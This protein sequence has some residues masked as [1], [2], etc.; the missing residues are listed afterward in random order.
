MADPWENTGP[1]PTALQQGVPLVNKKTGKTEFVPTNSVQERIDSGE[2]E[3]TGGVAA[4]APGGDIEVNPRELTSLR[5]AGTE[6]APDVDSL[7]RANQFA[8]E[9]EQSR[10]DQINNPVGRAFTFAEGVL[11]AFSMGVIDDKTFG[12]GFKLGNKMFFKMLNSATGEEYYIPQEEYDKLGLANTE[13]RRDLLT[14]ARQDE[15]AGT[16][17][18][19]EVAGTIGAL[20]IPGGPA[21]GAV[22]VGKGMGR[23][24]AQTVLG[25]ARAARLPF[26]TRA[27]EEAGAG[28]ILGGVHSFNQQVSDAI[29]EDKPFVA[30]AVLHEA[31]QGA[32]FGLGLGALS[33][34]ATKLR[35]AARSAVADGNSLLNLKSPLSQSVHSDIREAI[36]GFDGALDTHA[37]QMEILDVLADEGHVPKSGIKAYRSAIEEATTTQTHLNELDMDSALSGKDD[38]LAVNWRRAMEDYQAK[39]VKVDDVAERARSISEANQFGQARQNMGG[40]IDELESAGRNTQMEV[41]S[42][43]GSGQPGKLAMQVHAEMMANPQLARAYEEIYGRPWTPPPELGGEQPVTSMMA[44]GEIDTGTQLGVGRPG[45]ANGV[46]NPIVTNEPAV[47]EGR[48]SPL[49]SRGTKVGPAEG[50]RP[51]DNV[52]Q[53]SDV[54]PVV[55]RAANAK[56]FGDFQ[57]SHL[58]EKATGPAT[59]QLSAEELPS[60]TGERTAVREAPKPRDQS[61]KAAVKRFLDEWYNQ[62]RQ[63]GPKVSPAD[64]AAAKLANVMDRIKT[65][66]GGALDSA[67]ALDIQR[68]KGVEPASTSFGA[69]IDQL[70]AAR[71]I[72][73]AAA[74]ASRGDVGTT[75]KL[76]NRWM[77]RWLGGKAGYSAGGPIGAI[78]GVHLSNQLVGTTAKAAGIAGKLTKRVAAAA[79]NILSGNRKTVIAAAVT[80]RKT[81]SIPVYS[82]AGPIKDPVQRILEVQRMAANP[83]ALRNYIL[84]KLGPFADTH[85]DLAGK[86][87]D[88][89]AQRMTGLAIRAP[90]IYFNQLGVPMPPPMQAMAKYL[91]FE[92]ASNDL[93]YTLGKVENGTANEHTIDALRTSFPSVY[94]KLVSSLLIDRDKL[95][96][97]DRDRLKEISRLTNIPLQSASDPG[98]VARQQQAW[99]QFSTTN[100]VPRQ[101]TGKQNAPVKDETPGQAGTVAPG[102]R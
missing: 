42:R 93:E 28:A 87:A 17:M 1:V 21:S 16:R 57:K 47:N 19:G 79:D 83:D 29:L 90:A 85:P 95:L 15:F 73:S 18:A 91:E 65:E 49:I 72:G 3:G 12:K 8:S 20:A 102:N 41:E 101:M 99:A 51:F 31:A 43:V 69:Q 9:V 62:S 80:T 33:G 46:A 50:P 7:Q 56:A 96:A 61:G 48:G 60:M 35:G 2:Y 81:E 27:A 71:Q 92:F 78:L 32:E 37:S 86:M 54:N 30:E 70:V 34:V 26:I 58:A 4:R 89:Q 53:D 39:L 14:Q 6:A 88:L 98:F 63:M 5:G 74:D 94:S 40:G 36:Q 45:E 55:D 52:I 97:A 76:A 23:K 44:A 24:V 100:Q 38:K 84:E 11:D 75:S 22:D 67:G 77:L 66:T 64:R 10:K 13:Q 82:E 59:A 68:A 25:E